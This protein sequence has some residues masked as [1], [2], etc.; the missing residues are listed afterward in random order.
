MVTKPGEGDS[1]Q[2]EEFRKRA[3]PMMFDEIR[4]SM[5]R[6]QVLQWC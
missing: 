4:K 3:V 5:K 1:E 6:F 2:R